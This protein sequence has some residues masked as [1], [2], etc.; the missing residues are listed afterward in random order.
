MELDKIVF[1]C[2]IIIVGYIICFYG[3]KLKNL[4]SIFVWFLFGFA[5]SNEVFKNIFTQIDML[6]AFS[7]MIGLSCSLLSYKLDLLNI[8]ICVSWMIGT[9]L[10]SNLTFDP[11]LNLII[12]IIVG[13]IAGLISIKF[14]KPLVI[15]ATAIIGSGIM[16]KSLNFI[17]VTITKELLLVI[18]LFIAILGIIYQFRINRVNK[19]VEIVEVTE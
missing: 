12:S 5:F 1:F 9:S 2:F 17:P 19:N 18:Q 11:N 8:F 13:V 15:I 7:T 10:Y 16:I 4:L 3:L 6:H 14:V